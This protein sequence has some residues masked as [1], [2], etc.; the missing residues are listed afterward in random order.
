MRSLLL[1]AISLAALSL[2]CSGGDSDAQAAL[3]K[4]GKVVFETNC[5]ACHS[6]DPRLDGPVGPGNACASSEL[7]H[8]KV[9]RNEYPP[10][11]APKRDTQAMAPLPH[12]EKE[13]PALAAYLQS[14]GCAK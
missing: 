9:L 10:G 13:L 4:R 6:P 11:Y 2:A 8:A 14:L 7:L 3:V 1:L 12:L 5:T